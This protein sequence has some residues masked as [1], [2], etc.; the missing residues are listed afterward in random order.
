MV[1]LMEILSVCCQEFDLDQLMVSRLI[2]MKVLDLEMH[3]ELL[4]NSFS[5]NMM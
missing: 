4:T 3:L 2:L 5:V 1:F